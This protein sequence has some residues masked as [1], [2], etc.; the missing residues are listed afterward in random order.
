MTFSILPGLNNFRYSIYQVV[1]DNNNNND[2]DWDD[3]VWETISVLEEGSFTVNV[4]M[5]EIR[6]RRDMEVRWEYRCFP[7]SRPPYGPPH[8]GGQI[9]RWE[10][11]WECPR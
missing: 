1:K 6:E 2:D 9:C 5:N 4:I 3:G 10:P 7:A 11:V 8:G